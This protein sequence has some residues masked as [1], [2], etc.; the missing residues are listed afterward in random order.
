[1]VHPYNE[2]L[3]N[4]IQEGGRKQEEEGLKKKKRF[5]LFIEREGERVQCL[6]ISGREKDWK[7]QRIPSRLHAELRAYL[8]ILKS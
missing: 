6:C 4:N 3:C 1:M 5:C 8:T 7:S 2:M